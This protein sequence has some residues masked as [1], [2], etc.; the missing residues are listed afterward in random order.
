MNRSYNLHHHLWVALDWLYPPVCAGCGRNGD[1][2]CADC[3]SSVR[4]IHGSRCAFCGKSIEKGRSL[5]AECANDPVY[6]NAAAYWA[7][8]GGT[9]REAIHALKYKQDVGLGDYFASFM[10]NIIIENNWQFDLVIPV[11]LSRTRMRERGYNQS[12]LL[13]RPIARY[14]AIEHTTSALTRVKETGSQVNRSRFER[15][16]S[17]KDAFFGNPAKLK[18]RKVLLV[19]DII[20]T[21]STINHCSKALVE[22]G[23]EK[24]MAISIAKTLKVLHNQDDTAP[25]HVNLKSNGG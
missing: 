11:P 1:R 14:F 10:I 22:A 12:A 4:I 17:L 8:Y 21:G 15:D 23:A 6:F 25:D 24:V 2:Y 5:C 19:D 7:E 9:L 13:S 20:T 3:L 18:G 16:E